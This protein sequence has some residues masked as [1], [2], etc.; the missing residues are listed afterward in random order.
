M[1]LLRLLPENSEFGGSIKL[2]VSGL[3]ITA[4]KGRLGTFGLIFG[5]QLEQ[6]Q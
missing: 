2:V 6:L 5:L 4:P 1:S 3:S